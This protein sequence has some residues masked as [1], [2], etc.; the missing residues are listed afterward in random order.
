LFDFDHV[1]CVLARSIL[2]R[3]WCGLWP[4]VVIAGGQSEGF[5]YLT[6]SGSHL[7]KVKV[8]GLWLESESRR[9][10]CYLFL[11]LQVGAQSP[12]PQIAF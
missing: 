5:C 2:V 4:Y 3:N 11:R 7:L 9:N 8:F 6:K 1:R 10:Y 12:Q